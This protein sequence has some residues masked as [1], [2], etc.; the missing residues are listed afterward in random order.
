LT[1]NKQYYYTKGVCVALT[2]VRN[3]LFSYHSLAWQFLAG[4]GS[5]R[6]RGQPKAGG[7]EPPT[8]PSL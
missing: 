8:H 5:N 2:I 1:H 7:A 4:L 6:C 3:S